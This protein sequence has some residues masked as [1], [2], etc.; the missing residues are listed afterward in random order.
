MKLVEKNS[1]NSPFQEYK[2]KHIFVCFFQELHGAN[3]RPIMVT[4][5]NILT[6][7]SVSR[8]CGLVPPSDSLIKVVATVEDGKPS[9]Q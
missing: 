5:D 3:I 1:T 4:G 6:A 2:N 7:V 8:N 9:F